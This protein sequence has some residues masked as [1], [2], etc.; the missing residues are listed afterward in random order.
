MLN[1]VTEVDLVT[2]DF[3][4]PLRAMNGVRMSD[5]TPICSEHEESAFLVEIRAREISSDSV[6]DDSASTTLGYE[7]KASNQS[8]PIE[9]VN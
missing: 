5:L 6:D 3:G 2:I 4:C 1:A 8:L 7:V 9:C